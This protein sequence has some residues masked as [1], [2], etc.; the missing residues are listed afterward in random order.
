MR[1]TKCPCCNCEPIFYI[2]KDNRIVMRCPDINCD[3]PYAVGGETKE[4]AINLWNS[5]C[6]NW[7]KE[8]KE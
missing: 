1:I 4:K 2:D 6:S 3:F 8:N 5:S 7:M